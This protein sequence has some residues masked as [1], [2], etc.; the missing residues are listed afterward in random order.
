[1]KTK[2]ALLLALVLALRPSGDALAATNYFLPFATAPTSI[3]TQ[4]EYAADAQRLTGNQPNSVARS[5]LMNKVLRQCSTAAAG[6]GHFI[7]F[8]GATD[9]TDGMAPLAY[10]IA[11]RE[12]MLAAL[13]AGTDAT[14]GLVRFAT[15]PETVAGTRSDRAVTPAGL[16]TLTASLTRAGLVELATSTGSGT[17]NE[18]ITGTDDARA[19]TPLGLARLTSTTS[20]KGLIETATVEEAEGG[21]DTERAVTPAG[22]SAGIAA[23]FAGT[24]ASPGY[25]VFPN[26]LVME[27]GSLTSGSSPD[28]VTFPLAFP[29]AA[30]SI[31]A[32]SNNNDTNIGVSALSTT[33]FTIETNHSGRTLYWFAVGH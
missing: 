9:A 16:K 33:A 6:V 22:L 15:A 30:F 23:A 27:W 14:P 4:S 5:G 2:A 3:L 19:V 20:R 26:G 8:W 24:I 28:S 21:T 17:E 11:L 12:A 7:A 10:S 18:V 1:M 32:M 31:Q 29:T 13:P 25:V